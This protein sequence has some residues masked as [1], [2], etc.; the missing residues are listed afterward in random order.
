MVIETAVVCG[1]MFHTCRLMLFDVCKR[2]SL[3]DAENIVVS[4]S[5][6]VGPCQHFTR[7]FV[8][9]LAEYVLAQVRKKTEIHW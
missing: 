2:K 5:C 4:V 8:N 3:H 7:V 6:L 1:A 9:G